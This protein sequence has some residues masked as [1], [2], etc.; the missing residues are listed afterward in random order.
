MQKRD[1]ANNIN[2]EIKIS[3]NTQNNSNQNDANN[4]ARQI[5]LH[6]KL[7]ARRG[8]NREEGWPSKTHQRPDKKS[9][10]TAGND[11]IIPGNHPIQL[12]KTI[13][14]LVDKNNDLRQI[15]GPALNYE[16]VAELENNV[17]LNRMCLEQ[18][19]C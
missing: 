3:N 4:V 12:V 17:N 2:S 14:Q 7:M 5:K 15:I 1:H 18:V 19:N 16:K 8:R 10:K 6:K 11:D 9:C 13:Y